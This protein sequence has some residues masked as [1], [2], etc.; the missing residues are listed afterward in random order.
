M[1]VNDDQV[2]LDRTV[3]DQVSIWKSSR[4]LTDEVVTGHVC[5]GNTC[6]YSQIGDVFICEKTGRV[7]GRTPLSMTLLENDLHG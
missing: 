2:I 4:G 5:S 7:H 3:A 1:K 6:S